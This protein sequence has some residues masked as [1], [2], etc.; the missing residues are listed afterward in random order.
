M[1]VALPYQLSIKLRHSVVLIETI[2]TQNSE[3][4]GH[5]KDI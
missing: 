5:Y 3:T 4:K 1:L 2:K